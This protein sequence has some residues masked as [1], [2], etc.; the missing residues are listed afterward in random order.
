MEFHVLAFELNAQ[1]VCVVQW[2]LET[3]L[4][5]MVIHDVFAIVES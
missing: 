4:P 2:D 5:S 3:M 1:Q